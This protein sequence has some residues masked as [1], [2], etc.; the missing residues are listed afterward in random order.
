MSPKKMTTK[1]GPVV[2]STKEVIV[3]TFVLCKYHDYL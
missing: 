1:S 3:P 2:S